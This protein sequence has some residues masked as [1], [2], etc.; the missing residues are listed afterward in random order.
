M[1]VQDLIAALILIHVL[2][3]VG[4]GGDQFATATYDGCATSAMAEPCVRQSQVN[5]GV[6]FTLLKPRFDSNTAFATMEA[7][8]ASFESHSNTEFTYDLEF[9]PRIWLCANRHDGVGICVSFWQ[10]D[11]GTATE[12]AAPE[13]G[14]GRID[15]PQF[16]DVDIS[17]TVP[18]HRF[19]ATTSLEACVIDVEATKRTRLRS[20]SVAFGTG[21]RLA[22]L[23]QTYAAQ[24][25]NSN[26]VALGSIDYRH[27]VDGLGPT[28]SLSALRPIFPCLSVYGKARGSL[29]WGD[30]DSNLNTG[31]DLDLATPFKTTLVHERDDMLAI[32]ELQVG[33][34]WLANSCDQRPFQPFVSTA[35]EGQFW[36][37]AGNATTTT[38][39]LG[40]FGFSIGVGFLR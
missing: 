19:E 34:L 37:N 38:A 22:S 21:L 20:W 31:E 40:F 7:D 6:E 2:T 32:A 16:G 26:G 4:I 33:L 35:F 36:S 3:S 23:E 25:T 24:L 12:T 28:M 18:G 27:S 39:D 17:T 29:L 8:G 11:Q 9:S 14:F 30:G 10:F 13:N 5:A 1:S 15:H